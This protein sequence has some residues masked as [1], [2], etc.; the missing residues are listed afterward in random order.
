MTAETVSFQA[1]VGKVL[2]LFVH[3][4]YSE[5]EIFLREL[6]SN[7][8]DACDKLRY[9]GLT[10]PDLIKDDPDF[11]V[12]LTPDKAARTLTVSDN[13]IGMSRDELF[14]NLGT[15]AR[16]GTSA[17]LDQLTGDAKKDMALIGQF[18]VGFYSAFMVADRVEVLTR[19]AGAAEAWRWES[20]G[21]DSFTVE[22]AEKPGRGTDIVL[23]L[24]DDADDYLEPARLRHIVKTYSDHIGLPVKLAVRDDKEDKVDIET[25]NAA[26]ALWARPK[27]E[28]TD[29]QYTEF[30]HHV[31]HAFDDPWLT[32]HYRAEGMIEYATLL[33][34]PST[35]P[36]DL[37]EPER[38]HG[39]K[40]Y[41]RRVFI[42]DDCAE[43]LPSWL[44][45]LRGVV[46]SED[47][48]LNVS[49]QTL[50]DNPVVA[51][52]RSGLVKRVLGELETRAK[53]DAEGYAGF[54]ENFGAV[55]K[56][57]LYEGADQRDALLGLARFRTTRDEGWTSL[58]DYVARMKDGQDHIFT[59]A[60]DD[61]AAL[62]RSPQ[63]EGYAA[64]G[65]EV[66][67]L[68]DP[69]DKFWMPAVGAFDGKD[70]KSVTQGA[71]DLDKIAKP[72]TDADADAPETADADALIAM[73]KLALEDEVKD[74]RASDRL[75]ESPV[76]LVA[77]A[78]D[79]DMHLERLLKKARNLDAASK[80]ILEVNP[81]HPL[82]R[83]LAERA[84][85]DGDKADVS[86]IARL[87]LDQARISEGE[88]VPDPAAFSRR[89]A[90]ALEKGLAA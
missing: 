14:E 73:F 78:A 36:F 77:D 63:L 42:T 51:K 46:D 15:I 2:H 8:S 71:A 50:Q 67:L 39:L 72:E 76:C 37:F 16:S 74:V 45:F 60:G 38:R 68:T 64:R 35:P 81:R 31:A 54:W 82:I 48:P 88:P 22:E 43:L 65:V 12:T 24:R 69:V 56:E 55:L 90:S 10:D 70:F 75:T 19:R 57:G 84:A 20:E 25:V 89:L 11:A 49:R 1:E 66:L 83:A 52:I 17:F 9:A 34:V 85:A 80:R 27:S 28:I 59:I 44:R 53:E 4:L 23:H 47:L 18:G 87:L 61:L 26:A 33:F 13:G 21:K 30:Y 41:V 58:A 7:A 32:V 29:D 6:I 5:K 79:M 3:S 40:L 86:D 62:R